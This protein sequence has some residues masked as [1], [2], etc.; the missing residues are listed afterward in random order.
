VDIVAIK[1]RCCENYYACK[2]CHLA[3][4]N[5]PIALWPRDEFH[6]QAIL[7]GA[8]KR[9]L[10]IYEYL[11]CESRCPHCRA[12]FNPAC[13]SHHHFYFDVEKSSV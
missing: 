8:C 7:C 6:H 1:M 5:H 4:A 11:H 12:A 10:T 3:L 13:A 9:E 2:D